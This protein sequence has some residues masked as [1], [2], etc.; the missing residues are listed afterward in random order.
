MRYCISHDT[1]QG[2]ALCG[3]RCISPVKGVAY[4][5]DRLWGIDGAGKLLIAC[6]G[7]LAVYIAMA[8]G[9]YRKGAN[10]E[11]TPSSNIEIPAKRFLTGCKANHA[12]STRYTRRL[13]NGMF[14][15]RCYC[16]R[17]QGTNRRGRP[18][19]SKEAGSHR[20]ST[21]PTCA[22]ARRVRRIPP[23]PPKTIL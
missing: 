15:C 3:R 22:L 17:Y 16:H 13:G 4:V 7:C 10:N 11:D 9:E 6:S 21:W 18:A 5:D 1:V 19:P 20:G 2:T 8:I 14:R 23:R 12:R